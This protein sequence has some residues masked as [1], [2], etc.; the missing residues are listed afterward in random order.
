MVEMATCALCGAQQVKTTMDLTGHGLRCLQCSAKSE[1][2]AFKGARNDMAEHL[3][4]RE[5]E[6][7]VVAG[8]RE[9]L[10]GAGLAIGG[11]VLTSVMLSS[12]GQVVIVFSGMFVAGIGMIFHGLHRR[13]Q[14]KIALARMPDARVVR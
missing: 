1:Y 13:K 2:D 5:I 10:G 14:A 6:A 8:G 7:V 11:V 3:T 12:G 4:V 9:A